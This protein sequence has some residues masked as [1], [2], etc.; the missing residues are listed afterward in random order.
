MNA[1][2]HQIRLNAFPVQELTKL[3]WL[4]VL[5]AQKDTTAS[6]QK[7]YTNVSQ[8][9]MLYILLKKY[10]CSVSLVTFVLVESWTNVEQV[11]TRQLDR[12]HAMIANL[13]KNASRLLR[14]SHWIVR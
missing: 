1:L 2:T 5:T 14:K 13:V 4:N 6:I 9:H 7:K 3:V 11:D 12:P 8:E 10:V